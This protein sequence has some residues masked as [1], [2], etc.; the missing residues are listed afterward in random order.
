MRRLLLSFIALVPFISSGQATVTSDKSVKTHLEQQFHFEHLSQED[1]LSQGSVYSV[2]SY[3]GYMWFGTQDGLNRFDGYSFRVFRA[4]PEINNAINNSWVSAL[5]ADTKGRFWVGTKGGLCTYNPE[6]E[7]FSRFREVFKVDHLIDSVSIER[8][9]EDGN[10]DIWVMTDEYGLF[11]IDN[12]THKVETHLPGNN[13][14]FGFSLGLDGVLWVSTYDDIYRYDRQKN[15]MTPINIKKTLQKY[16][17]PKSLIQGLLIDSK[18]NMWIGTYQEGVFRIQANTGQISVYEKN[19][20]PLGIKSNEIRDFIED[21]YGRIWLASKGGAGL[22]IFN[23]NTDAFYSITRTDIN[24][25]ALIDDFVLNF[26]M[27]KQGIVWMG[28]SNSGIDKYDPAK[29]EFGIIGR[30]TTALD[31]RSVFA[32]LEKDDH[33]YIGTQSRLRVFSLK[34]HSYNDAIGKPFSKFRSEVYGI[35]K[36]A[37][38]N[39][40]VASSDIGLY[41]FDNKK[42]YVAYLNKDGKDERLYYLYTVKAL[43]N[44]VELW[45][46]GHKGIER[47]NLESKSWMNWND[48][49]ALKAISN[50]TTRILYEDSRE[51]IWFGTYDHGL[52]QYN[53]KTK[54]VKAFNKQNH[55]SCDNVRSILEDGKTIWV[56]T[57]CGLFELDFNGL[58][59]KRHFSENGLPPFQIPNNVIYGILKDNAGFLWLS[60]NRGLAKFSPQK[61]IVKTYNV[62][63]GLQGNEFNTNSAYKHT[64]GTMFFGGVYG[65]SYFNPKNLKT[66]TFIPPVKIIGISVM[67]STYVA[68]QKELVLPYDQNFIDFE[69]AALNYS[70]SSKNQYQHKMENIDEKWIHAGTKRTANYTNLPPGTY[71]FKVIGSNNDGV[72]NKEGASVKITILPP[73]WGTW[74]FRALLILLLAGGVYGL[75]LYRLDQQLRQREAEIRASLMAQEAERQRFSR[76]LHDGVGANLSLLKMYLASFGDK[77]VPMAELKERSEKLLA[78]SVDEIRRLIHDMH[79]RNLKELGLVKAVEEMVQLVNLGNGLKVIFTTKSIPGHLPETVEIN[80]FRIIQELLQNAIRH[81]GAGNVWLDLNYLNEKVSLTYQD[82]GIGFDTS[83][84]SQGNGLLNIRNRVMLFK[85]HMVVNSEV[86]RGTQILTDMYM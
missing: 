19:T 11:R 15:S 77:D 34:S 13:K 26:F 24:G 7:N 67:D 71:T 17:L 79:P 14:L 46:G 42:G 1:G 10:G 3:H 83:V 8:L 5:L 43:K 38:G 12:K 74:W 82:D 32:I 63:D 65:I 59:V 6:K 44:T 78:G 84:V 47:Y 2:G 53:S 35:S 28:M 37:S 41:R 4:R 22:A 75:F 80:L 68:T 73:W 86:G 51:N 55:F 49:P 9:I 27:D 72:W 16:L 52:F 54:Q 29:Y 30:E 58:A 36:D 56:G 31:S 50:F 85:G 21:S 23:Y 69:F 76:E 62:A 45:T 61:G 48:I 64:D 70:S 60:S 81:S 18:G 57:D 25:N 33:L 66:N 39:L 40:W 20:S